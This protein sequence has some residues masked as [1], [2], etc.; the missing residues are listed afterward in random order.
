MLRV[1]HHM[2]T[3]TNT[4]DGLTVTVFPVARGW[5]VRFIDND[6]GSII[7]QCIYSTESAAIA[8]A[9]KIIGVTP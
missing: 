4:D 5:M 8:Y 9:H 6:S 7:E 1:L 3:L 2:I